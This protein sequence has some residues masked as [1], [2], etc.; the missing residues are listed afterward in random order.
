MIISEREMSGIGGSCQAMNAAGRAL[1]LAKI[2]YN[3]DFSDTI[4]V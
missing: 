1:F 2:P 4:E 3:V